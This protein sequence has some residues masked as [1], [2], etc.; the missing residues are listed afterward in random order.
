MLDLQSVFK[1]LLEGAAV[2]VAAF[3]IP[4]RKVD[5]KEIAMIAATAAVVFMVL[6]M[7][8][9]SVALGARQGAGF[10]IGRAMV[11]GADET[12]TKTETE[13][14]SNVDTQTTDSNPDRPLRLRKRDPSQCNQAPSQS[15]ETAPAPA[16]STP[17][18]ATKEPFVSQPAM[19]HY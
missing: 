9:P 16:A 3:Y 18:A 11:G 15:E 7:F 12:E 4:Q 14:S 6:D 17:V 2:A 1:Y 8:A 10:G 5:L 19:L 13:T